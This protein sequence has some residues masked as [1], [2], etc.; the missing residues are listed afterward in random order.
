MI[1]SKISRLLNPLI[2]IMFYY[3]TFIYDN[4]GSPYEAAFL[5]SYININIR[6]LCAPT[7]LYTI[8]VIWNLPYAIYYTNISV[9]NL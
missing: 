4:G 2:A 9:G 1:P 5:V 3:D 8:E 7:N 6:V